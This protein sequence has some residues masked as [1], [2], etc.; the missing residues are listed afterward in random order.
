MIFKRLNKIMACCVL[1]SAA[2]HAADGGGVPGNLDRLINPAVGQWVLYRVLDTSSGQQM[3]VRQSIIGKKTVDGRDAY[4]IETDVMSRD[5]G[6]F[7]RKALI[8]IDPTEPDR[9]LEIIEKS[10]SSPAR[11]VPVPEQPASSET[12]AGQKPTVE[13]VGEETLTTPAGSI[14]TRHVR[15]SSAEGLLDVWTS[16]EIGLSGMVKRTSPAG[17]MELISYGKTGAS[18]A[19]MEQPFEINVQ[20]GAQTTAP[21]AS[22]GE[23]KP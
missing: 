15:V 20:P 13:D 19:I 10:G 11:K 4:W 2:G 14:R 12:P 1:V 6:R 17:E 18:S 8:A 21:E 22:A 16:D 7:I 5:G 23:N 9:I 3:T